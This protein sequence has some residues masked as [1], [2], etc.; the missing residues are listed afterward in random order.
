[1][2]GWMP[3]DSDYGNGLLGS[4][5]GGGLVVEDTAPESNISKPNEDI[6]VTLIVDKQEVSLG[7]GGKGGDINIDQVRCRGSAEAMG[8]FDVP[9]VMHQSAVDYHR[10][11]LF[12]YLI[13][14]FVYYV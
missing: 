3:L 10:F 12:E 9:H 7:L 1:M 8:A 2:D 11:L 5:S 4:S 13:L 14:V 6:T